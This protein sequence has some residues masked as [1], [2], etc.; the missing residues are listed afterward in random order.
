VAGGLLGLACLLAAFAKPATT[1]AAGLEPIPGPES[2]YLC[3][4]RTALR[5]PARC[6]NLGPAA[7]LVD[8][9]RQGRIDA[10]LPTVSLDPNLGTLPFSYLRLSGDHAT[11]TYSSESDARDGKHASGQIEA[12]FDYVSYT[13]CTIKNGKAVFYLSSGVFMRGGSDC[14]Q[15]ATSPFHG[16]AFYRTPERPFGWV[17]GGMFTAPSPGETQAHTSDWVNR[18]QVV[19]IYDS[20]DAGGTTWYEIAPGEWLEARMI[21]KV[22]PDPVRP[23]S[24]KGDQWI[25]IN[26]FEQ[27]L[28]AYDHGQMVFATLVASGLPG[29]WTRPGDFQIT[30]KLDK[31]VMSGAFAAD[32]SD[33]YYLQDVPWTM[34]F[35]EARALHGAYWHNGF[36]YPR[37]HGCVNLS[38]ADSHWLYDWA[39]EGTWVHVWDP[40]G[41]TPTDDSAYGAGGA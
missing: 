17:L 27:T 40:S 9:A 25:S 22:V 4:G 6:P 5:E 7:A 37:S 8:E 3:T 14:G 10:P 32:R 21:A 15:I 41:K 20:A 12:G 36:G 30:S 28:A 1:E 29:W 39:P 38:P 13:S 26:L 34:Y 16:L 11:P 18:Y 23:A 19:Q 33:Y 24:V 35:D 31:T 2:D